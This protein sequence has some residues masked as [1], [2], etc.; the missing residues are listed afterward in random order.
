MDFVNPRRAKG[1]KSANRQEKGVNSVIWHPSSLYS[2]IFSTS[3]LKKP[4]GANFA[5]SHPPKGAK[6]AKVSVKAGK[7]ELSAPTSKPYP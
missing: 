1:A 7:A 3:C 4:K 2:S 5:G 6:S